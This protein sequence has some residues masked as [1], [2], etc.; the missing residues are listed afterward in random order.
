MKKILIYGVGP[1]GSL[2]A[3]R[4]S[5]ARHSIFLL[6]HGDRQQELKTYGVVTENTVTGER[7]VTRLPVVERLDEEDVYDLVIVPIRKNLVAD[8]LPALAANKKIPTFLFMMN[9]AAGQ[10]QFVEALGKER[11]MA[12]FPL[13]GGY[14]KS[15]IMYMMP[16]EEKKPTILPI[17]EVDGNVLPRTCEVA[18]ILSSMRGYRAEIRKDIDDWLKTH[19]AL[20]IP[21]LAPAV[22]AC[23]TD[24][25]HFAAT[26]DAHV[27][28]RRALPEAFQ[29]IQNAGVPITPP[30]LRI[31]GWLPEPVFVLAL[32]QMAKGKTF[33]NIMGHL[34]S[35]PD[36]VRHLTDE[37]FEL[38]RH[39]NTSTP[40]L[41][42]LA[43]YTYGTKEAIPFGSKS[44]PLQWGGIYGVAIGAVILAGLLKKARK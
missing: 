12:G 28:L 17:G 25:E 26:R 18:D 42:K 41:D 21:T 33:E 29:A 22:Y 13:P 6:D 14:K 11:V 24:F 44:I 27:L 1:F 15:Y 8:V 7:T 5:E 3:E 20:L 40:T 38:I 19:V 10:Q 16:V 4:L 9:N 36:E 30:A 2:F 39:G 32:G 31:I 35:V 37:F 34:E 23:N 43:E